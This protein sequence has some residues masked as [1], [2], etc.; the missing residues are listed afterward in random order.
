MAKDTTNSSESTKKDKFLDLSIWDKLFELIKTVPEVQKLKEHFSSHINKLIDQS[1]LPEYQVLFIFDENPIT[2]WTQNR[3]YDSLSQLE[4]NKNLLLIIENPGGSVESA[5]FISKAAKKFSNKFVVAI[6]R[7]AKSAATLLSL[8]ADEIHM[9][10]VSQLGPID[11][12]V[13]KLPALAVSNAIENIA[14]I[15]QRYPNAS[16][17]FARYLAIRVEPAT[18]GYFERIAESTVQYAERLLS[19]KELPKVTGVAPVWYRLVYEYKDHGFVIDY[20]EAVKLLGNN[21]V[22]TETKEIKLAEAIY[23]F[24]DE[25]NVMMQILR[26]SRLSILGNYK[27]GI[28]IE[29]LKK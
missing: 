28:Q 8:G 21:M 5:Y 4:G 10:V 20:D 19:S 25:A 2:E 23:K 24:L 22:K 6:P 7:K 15:C 12:Q 1:A 26:K 29:E 16:E 17:M 27:N 13:N 9:G 14:S 11:P 3:L 18:F